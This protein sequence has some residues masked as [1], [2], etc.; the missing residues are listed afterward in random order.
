MLDVNREYVLRIS[1]IGTAGA[2]AFEE[3]RSSRRW[4]RRGGRAEAGLL[5]RPKGRSKRRPYGIKPALDSVPED[6]RHRP[7][8]T[9]IRRAA[10]AQR[11]C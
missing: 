5:A 3:T 11:L 7:N 2:R 10:P 8:G 1:R 6:V 4:M 9:A